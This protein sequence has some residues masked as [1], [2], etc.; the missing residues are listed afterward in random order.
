M[1]RQHEHIALMCAPR[2]MRA[3]NGSVSALEARDAADDQDA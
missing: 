1:N 3:V 2:M